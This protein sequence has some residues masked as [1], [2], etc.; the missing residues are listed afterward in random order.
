MHDE[1]YSMLIGDMGQQEKDLLECLIRIDNGQPMDAR[2]DAL[3]DRLI[4]AGLVDSVDGVLKLT[5][6]GVRR[7]QSLQHREYGDNEA[8]RVLNDRQAQADDDAHER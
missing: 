7:C 3:L 8:A 6:A 5:L 1:R 4:R 2:A